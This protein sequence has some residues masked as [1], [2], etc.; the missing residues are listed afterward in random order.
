M[1]IKF[2]VQ[3][4]NFPHGDGSKPVRKF[5]NCGVLRWKGSGT[6]SKNA[7][8]DCSCDLW[9]DVPVNAKINADWSVRLSVIGKNIAM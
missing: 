6:K 3:I 5:R 4:R 7:E 9:K 8:R 2:A 1:H